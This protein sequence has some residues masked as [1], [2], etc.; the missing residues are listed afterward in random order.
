MGKD[1]NER[2][3]SSTSQRIVMALTGVLSF[4]MAA[5]GFMHIRMGL[6]ATGLLNTASGIVLVLMVL[7]FQRRG[8]K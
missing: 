3:A 2:K 8:R 6:V 7:Y 1:T 4:G 5:V